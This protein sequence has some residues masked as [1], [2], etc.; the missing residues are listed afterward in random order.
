MKSTHLTLEGYKD[1]TRCTKD[2]RKLLIASDGV[3]PTCKICL[4]GT[5]YPPPAAL[6]ETAIK[7]TWTAFQVADKQHNKRG[8]AFGK[9]LFEYKAGCEVVQGGTTFNSLLA[10]HKIPHS[11]AYVWLEKYAV[12][13]GMR[14]LNKEKHQHRGE[15]NFD[16]IKT[17]ALE[18]VKL[19]HKAML[20][21]GGAP[22]LLQAAKDW[23]YARLKMPL[24]NGEAAMFTQADM[25]AEY[26]RGY[27]DG[28]KAERECGTNAN[29]P[30]IEEVVNAPLHS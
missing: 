29:V 22:Y 27:A 30:Q 23:A 6:D 24:G 5:S 4:R 18:I 9:A 15:G 14:K 19:G 21:K 12:S 2:A 11:T 20:D 25:D 7:T 1:T 8:L 3:A 16:Q 28:L 17:D 13:I 10:K 26:R